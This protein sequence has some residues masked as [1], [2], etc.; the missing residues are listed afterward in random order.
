MRVVGIHQPNFIPW[1]G[2][3]YKIYKSDVFIFLNDA[4]FI[5]NSIADRNKIKTTQGEQYIKLPLISSSH[6]DNYNEVF[7]RRDEHWRKKTIKTLE[8]NYCKTQFFNEVMD[9]FQTWLAFSDDHLDKFNENIIRYITSKL[10][11]STHFY[12]SESFCIHK[13]S[14]E[15]LVDLIKAVDGTV[16]LSGKG[17]ANY[18][19]EKMYIDNDIQLVY[20]DFVHPIYPQVGKN[21]IDR[22]SII[23]LL[24]NC[25]YEKASELIINSK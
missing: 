14:T 22:L 15:R 21:F 12:E 1:V 7:V 23:D 9:D 8:M 6:L 20:T 5:K 13:K 25:G 18:Q 17:G 19:D 4:Q 24:F 11:F 10:G 16:Y 3:F 2:Y